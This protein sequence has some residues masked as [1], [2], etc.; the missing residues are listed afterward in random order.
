M[1]TTTT[2]NTT[3]KCPDFLES[4]LN[5]TDTSFCALGSC[6]NNTAIMSL[7]CNGAA[8]IPYYYDSGFPNGAHNETSGYATWCHV[9]NESGDRAWMDCV[10]SYGGGAGMCGHPTEKSSSARLS[11]EVGGVMGLVGLVVLLHAM[12]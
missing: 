1:N 10:S 8:V 5:M 9:A 2:T 12:L 6:G 11:S 4:P 7:C 3:S